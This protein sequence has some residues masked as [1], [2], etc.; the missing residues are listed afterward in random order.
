MAT[1]SQW[2]EGSR[3]RTWPA[4]FAPVAAGTGAALHE[5][6]V[7]GEAVDLGLV[8]PRALIALGV[9]LALQIGVNYANDYSDGV[10]GT[11]DER[12]GPFRLT[13]SGAARPAVV[14]RAA[15]LSL[16]VGAALGVILTVLSGAWWML[17]VGA[18]AVAAAWF[19]TGGSRPYGY[20]GLGEVF[21]FVFFGLVA[22]MGTAFAITGA[23]TLVALLAA[24]AIGLLAVAVL[25]TNNLR[26]IPTDT[27]AGKL[28]L[29]VR[30]GD[31]RTR[32][33]YAA[34]MIGPFA[35]LVPVMIAHWPAALVLLALPLA[36]APVRTV[37]AGA[38]GRGLIPV[39]GATG[40]VELVVSV[41]LLIGLA[42]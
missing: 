24:C 19:Y 28:T 8:L 15:V 22:V 1:F 6:S 34:C 4:A 42:I 36:V 7:R 2:V 30:L 14:K 33:L 10:R 11:D 40:R 26:D 23:F 16:G 13:G 12:V 38:A 21:V 20:L 18:A 35:L 37:L 5:L 17:A 32:L 39:L 31:R 41:L 9:A 27:E 29:A 25:V 3:P